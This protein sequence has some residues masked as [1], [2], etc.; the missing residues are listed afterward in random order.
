MKKDRTLVDLQ[1][2]S[3][4]FTLPGGKVFRAVDQ[5][6]LTIDSGVTLGLVGESGCGKSTVGR[7]LLRLYSATGGRIL[8]EGRDITAF[9]R[10]RLEYARCVQAVFQDP[11]GSLNPRM[12]IKDIITEPMLV[13]GASTGQ[14]RRKRAEELVDVVG[15]KPDHLRRFPHE[16]SGGQRQRIAIARAICLKPKFIVLDEPVSALDV[17][18]QAQIL[19]LLM[20]L[21]DDYGLSYLFISHDLSVVEHIS[22]NIAVMYLGRI[23]EQAAREVLFKD[24]RHP[25]TEALLSSVLP[26]DPR[27]PALRF[28]PEGDAADWDF[29]DKGCLFRNR[30]P[31]ALPI[32]SNEVPELVE[33]SPGHRVACFQTAGS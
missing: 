3:K 18:I 24:F 26:A 32:C 13:Q 29:Q 4:H 23:V 19:N 28:L 11:Y 6:S 30:C 15:L 21:Q 16:F 8:F 22:R 9:S 14:E 31:R 33:I 12:R 17:S 27:L 25:Y 5:V 20:D 10:G 7:C 1:K 2:L